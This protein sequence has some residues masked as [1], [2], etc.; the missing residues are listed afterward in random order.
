MR[1]IGMK[2]IST[3]KHTITSKRQRLAEA[4]IRRIT[5]TSLLST[6]DALHTPSTHPKFEELGLHPPIVTAL[7]RAF[8]DVV[9]PTEAQTKFIPAVLTGKDVLLKDFP[10]SGKSVAF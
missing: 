8:P 2:L 3:F 6:V 1:C 10:G 7:R 9:Y 5:H 4:C